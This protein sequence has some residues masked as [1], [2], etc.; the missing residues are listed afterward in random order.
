MLENAGYG[1]CVNEAIDSLQV[2]RLHAVFGRDRAQLEAD[3]NL[4]SYMRGLVGDYFSDKA[5][6]KSPSYA[7]FALHRFRTCLAGQKVRLDASYGDDLTFA[8]LTRMDIPYFYLV[9]KSA[10]VSREVAIGRV[11]SSLAGWHYPAGLVALLAEPSWMVGQESE[12]R[13]LQGFIFNTC[14]LPPDDVAQHYGGQSPAK[15]GAGARGKQ[16]RKAPGKP[17]K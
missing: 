17:V 15:G 7:H 16:A 2:G 11:D 3:P 14:M 4:S 8:C 12:L 6:G 5:A 1:Y 10:G 13:N 9:L